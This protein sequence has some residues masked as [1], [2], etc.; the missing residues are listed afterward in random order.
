LPN[1]PAKTAQLLIASG[2]EVSFMNRNGDTPLLIA[3]RNGQT[4]VVKLLLDYCEPE[5]V[6]FRA[7]IDGFDALFASVESDRPDCV[8]LIHEYGVSLEE[9]TADDNAILQS[10]TPLHLAAYYGRHASAKTL[11]ELGAD[12]NS[13]DINGMTPLHI[14][15]LR[16]HGLLIELLIGSKADPFVTDRSGNAPASFS[17]DPKVLALLV[18]PLTAPLHELAATLFLAGCGF[19]GDEIRDLLTTKSAVPGLTEPSTVISNA[20][21][22]RGMNPLIT[23]VIYGNFECVDILVGLGVDPELADSRRM[24]AQV[25]SQWIKNPRTLRAVRGPSTDL[26][27]TERIRAAIRASSESTSLLFI[28]DPQPLPGIGSILQMRMS[29][30]ATLSS[31]VDAS[32]PSRQQLIYDCPS[33]DLLVLYEKPKGKAPPASFIREQLAK[34]SPGSLS[35]AEIEAVSAIGAG[36]TERLTPP[37]LVALFLYS[38]DPIISD[39]VSYYLCGRCPEGEPSALLYPLGKALLTAIDTLPSFT[40]EVYA[41]SVNIDRGVLVEGEVVSSPTLISATSLWPI[42]VEALNFEKEGTVFIIK[43]KSG[44]LISTHAAFPFDSEVLFLPG[45]P[46]T[47]TRWYRGDVIALG[48]PNIREHTFGPN[49]EQRAA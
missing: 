27:Q 10:A 41:A 34:V 4:D 8:R 3:C 19:T 49:D 7:S 39:L 47:V 35:Q 16:K 46:F 5:L 40:A 43:S 13:C 1:G 20:L 25:W 26:S 15:V 18:N 30:L 6:Q 38:C 17:R 42:A 21:N 28:T 33:S 29:L 45:T 11:L 14:A 31:A 32:L 2:A 22:Q 48:Q 44:R 9:R 36:C 37:Q 12:P 23:S 24:S